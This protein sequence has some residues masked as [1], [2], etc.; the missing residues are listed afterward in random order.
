M[1]RILIVLTLVLGLNVLANAQ[2]VRVRMSFPVNITIGAPGHV[3]FRGAIW[4]GPEWRWQ[5]GHYVC[6]PGYWA[7]PQRHRAYVGG[8]W[9][10]G[11]HGYVWVPGR[12][13]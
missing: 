9:R 11:R 6:V 1:K 4:I 10:H 2:H 7:R 5:R 13:R 12:W 8:Y 3:P